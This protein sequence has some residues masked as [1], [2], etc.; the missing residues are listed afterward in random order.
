MVTGNVLA[1]VTGQLAA[2]DCSHQFLRIGTRR[3]L[4]G[5]QYP[6]SPCHIEFQ[7]GVFLTSAELATMREDWPAL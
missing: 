4:D 3:G 7:P 6:P 2:V 5:I 1:I